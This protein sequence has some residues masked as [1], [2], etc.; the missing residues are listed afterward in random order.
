MLSTLSQLTRLALGA[1]LVAALASAASADTVVVDQVNFTF[2]PT[3]VVINVGD[4]VRWVWNGGD[5]DVTEGTDGSVDGN[6]AFHNL[7]DSAN[8]VFEFTFDAA[9]LAANPR[10]GNVYDYFC[11]P[12][13]AFGMTGTVT[14]V[15]EPGTSFCDCPAPLAI[16]GNPGAPGAGCANSSGS[17]VVLSA[18]GSANALVDD[19]TLSGVGLLPGNAAL[20]FTG[21]NQINGGA[22][23][24]FG[25][26]LRCAGGQL[27]RIG[28][29]IP[30]GAGQASWGPG[31][32]SVGGWSSGDTRN[33]QIWYRD[34]N[35]S[36]CGN[37]FNVSNGYNVTFN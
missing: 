13:F 16:C 11:S 23:T 34:S 5:H 10:V 6:E 1:G 8:P 32:S 18:A 20:L 12:H 3:D 22:G 28:V 33:F 26:G 14:V 35:G 19:L 21:P 27:V 4:T 2:Q 30:N 37:A 24:P 15:D 7:L 17:G 9:F 29:R 25:D 36:P 31:L